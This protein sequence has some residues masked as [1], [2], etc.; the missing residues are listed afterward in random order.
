MHFARRV[1]N[2]YTLICLRVTS[3]SPYLSKFNTVPIA[4]D[5]LMGKLAYTP[6]L[7]VKVSVKK[8]K[9][10]APKM[11]T[12]TVRINEAWKKNVTAQWRDR[13]EEVTLK[14]VLCKCTFYS[15]WVI[16]MTFSGIMATKWKWQIPLWYLIEVNIFQSKNYM[17]K[18]C[19]ISWAFDGS[20]LQA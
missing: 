6:I 8:M 1:I 20:N 9:N 2:F 5:T 12:S 18:N 10:A 11:V 7:S 17:I 19:M 3:P 4:P 15:N 14:I 16:K 13:K